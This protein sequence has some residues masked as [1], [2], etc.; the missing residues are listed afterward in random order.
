MTNTQLLWQNTYRKVGMV[1]KNKEKNIPC[2]F[3]L[4]CKTEWDSQFEKMMRSRLVMGAIKYGR[5]RKSDTPKY[6][7]VA[8]IKKRL[9]MYQDTG[10]GEHLVD[11]ANIAMCE[12]IEQNH[13]NF[14]IRILDSGT[15]NE[16]EPDNHIT[17]GEK[18]DDRLI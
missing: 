10:N 17:N 16:I 1:Y 14:H 12:W 6:N 3:K 2:N 7:R 15:F 13:P 8:S 9:K 11:I 4:L 18:I 5:L